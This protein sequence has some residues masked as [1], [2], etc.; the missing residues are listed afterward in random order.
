MGKFVKSVVNLVANE[1]D[2]DYKKKLVKKEHTFSVESALNI[3]YIDDGKSEHTLDYFLPKEREEEKLPII[4]DIHGGGFISGDKEM[5]RIF[6]SYLA[7]DKMAVFSINYQIAL[8]DEV[9]VFSEVH[10]VTDALKFILTLSSQLNLD[11]SKIFIFGHSAGAVLAV[12]EALLSKS[13]K[14]RSLY[15]IEDFNPNIKGLFLDCGFMQVDR[16]EIPFWGVR[17]TVFPKDFENDERYKILLLRD[18]EE[19]KLLPSTFILTNNGDPLK[20]MSE[21]FKKAL[22][23]IGVRNHFITRGNEGHM[24]IIFNPESRLNSLSIKEAIRF[25]RIKQH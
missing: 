23:K 18:E 2:V 21:S 17:I 25:L 22:D 5:D 16:P 8:S 24:G 3:P 20:M 9:T 4:L 6:C 19:L 15:Q 7:Q 11:T 12:N 10:D 13:E 1:W 14:L